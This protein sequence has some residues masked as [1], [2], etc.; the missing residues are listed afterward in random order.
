MPKKEHHGEG[1]ETEVIIIARAPIPLLA[2]VY[3][4]TLEL[5]ALADFIVKQLLKLNPPLMATSARCAELSRRNSQTTRES[6]LKKTLR[7][8]SRLPFHSTSRRQQ[9][10]FAQFLERRRQASR[11]IEPWNNPYAST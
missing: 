3:P 9:R 6:G 4:S 1:S 5:R 2:I 11:T 8:D 10:A 7:S